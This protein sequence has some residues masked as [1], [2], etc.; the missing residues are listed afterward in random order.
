M[1]GRAQKH[2]QTRGGFIQAVQGAEG[3]VAFL[4]PEE[5]FDTELVPVTDESRGFVD[6]HDIGIFIED[7]NI[8]PQFG[9]FSLLRPFNQV[10]F[11]Q[12]M[13]GHPDSFAIYKDRTGIQQ[14]FG[15]TA[16][17]M[18]FITKK[19]LEGFSVVALGY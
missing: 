11:A 18:K 4:F 5:G 14:G 1:F 2:Q 3:G 7:I 17:E 6:R 10:I 16:T 12:G 15:L 13:F 8:I 9:G 19:L